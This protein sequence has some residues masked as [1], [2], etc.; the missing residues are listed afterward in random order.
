MNDEMKNAV[1]VAKEL[2]NR[3][4]ESKKEMHPHITVEGKDGPMAIAIAPSLD[5]DQMMQA[6]V[7]C[8]IGFESESLVLSYDAKVSTLKDSENLDQ[9]STKSDKLE[10]L[11]TFRIDKNGKTSSVISPYI[12]EKNKIRWID[13]GIT[14]HEDSNEEKLKGDIPD[15]LRHIWNMKPIIDDPTYGGEVE[16][17]IANFPNIK[18]DLSQEQ[19]SFL[20]SR[21]IMALLMQKKFNIIDNLSNK[22]IEWT[23]AKQKACEF[24]NELVKDKSIDASYKDKLIDCINQHFGTPI[25]KEKTEHYLMLAKFKNE[26]LDEISDFLNIME[27]ICMTPYLN[28]GSWLNEQ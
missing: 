4:F 13:E 8:R 2:K 15:F 1:I 3:F 19:I 14:F 25:F 11:L 24:I 17:I 6:C 9:A 12:V 5:R 20:I 16:N 26:K 28:D 23:D 7:M 10:C 22:H 21:A 18:K 27:K